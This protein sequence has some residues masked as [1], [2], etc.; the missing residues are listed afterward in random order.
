MIDIFD[1]LGPI[2]VGPSSSHT[3]GAVRIGNMGRTLLGSTPVRAAIHLHGSFAETGVGHGTDK[4]LVAGLLGLKADDYDIPNSFRLAKERG[5]AFTF[6]EVQ[7]K[8]AHPNS[9]YMELTDHTGHVLRFQACSV[10]GGRIEVTKLDSVDVNF[11]GSFHTLI[12][13][14]LDIRGHVA[15]VTAALSQAGINIA[16]MS[17]CRDRRGGNAITL[18]EMDEKLPPA[19]LE[20]LSSFS[21]ITH[22][23]YYEKED[24]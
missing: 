16:N 5:L 15:D 23:T 10:G 7:L 22:I 2:M 4:A 6:D 21:G 13:H 14:N 9:V 24:E 8:D 19:V 12:I 3:A 20:Q 18:I 1:I 17:L 11:T